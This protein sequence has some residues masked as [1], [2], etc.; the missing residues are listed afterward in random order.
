MALVMP[1]DH[2]YIKNCLSQEVIQ[3][4]VSH[5]SKVTLMNY[6]SNAWVIYM[7]HHAIPV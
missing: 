1:T 5:L 7:R 2:T 3:L 4:L 6:Q